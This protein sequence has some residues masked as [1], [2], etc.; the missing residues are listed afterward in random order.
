MAELTSMQRV[1]KTLSFKKADRIP[2]FLM[3]TITGA[4][5]LGLSIEEYFSDPKH[6]ADGQ[7]RMQKKYNN[8]CY[9]AFYYSAIENE[10]F[11]GTT[12]FSSDGPPN[13]G[14]PF[15]QSVEDIFQL[16]VPN[17]DSTVALQKVLQ[18]TQ[19]LKKASDGNTPVI[20]VVMSPF[21]LP[22]MQM[23]F[24][25]YFE[26][27][28]YNTAAFNALMEK[29]KAFC[30]NWANAQIEA[31]AD[32]ITYFDPLASTTMLPKAM[33]EQTGFK[34][35]QQVI[36]DIKAPVAYHLASNTGLPIVDLLKKSGSDALFISSTEKVSA[37]QDVVSDQVI[38][39]NLN[40]LEMR[41]WTPQEATNQIKELI[42]QANGRALIISDNHGEIPYQVK[43]E[44]L[45]AISKAVKK[46]GTFQ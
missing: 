13:S 37:Y 25:K 24:D 15:I 32:I 42:H 3:L 28:H 9:Y 7:I 19:L 21:S 34:I 41:N 2:L 43:D 31:G 18:T 22:V 4:K 12:V 23:G 36:K 26:L 39:G 44:T 16:N 8:D 17:I 40:G 35:A 5:E 27:L 14:R 11:G 30:T 45:L 29:N 1:L 46:Y 20:G 6:V 10:A 33:Y 38:I